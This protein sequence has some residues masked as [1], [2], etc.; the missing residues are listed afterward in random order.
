MNHPIFITD[1]TRDL[2]RSL[3]PVLKKK[4]RLALGEIRQDPLCAK[5]LIQELEG[6]RSYKLGMIRIIYRID[7]ASVRIVAI[8]PRHNIYEQVILEIKRSKKIH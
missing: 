5:A 2:L 6:L 3:P 4:I 7:H 1:E 8:G